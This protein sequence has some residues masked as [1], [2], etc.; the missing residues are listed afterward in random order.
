MLAVLDHFSYELQ[1]PIKP[2]DTELTLNGNAIKRLNELSAGDHTY[3]VLSVSDKYEIVK[4]TKQNELV[5]NTITVERDV[6][7]K[8]AKNFPR[9]SCVKHEW[10]KVVMDEYIAQVG[11]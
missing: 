4:F 11:R 8:G 2:T 7:N 6:E 5:G 9:H 1:C 3:L 10:V